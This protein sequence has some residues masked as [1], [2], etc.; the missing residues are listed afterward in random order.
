MPNT[1]TEKKSSFVA[2]IA[3]YT[4]IAESTTK[5]TTTLTPKTES[6]SSS[7]L[8]MITSDRDLVGSNPENSK[9]VSIRKDNENNLLFSDKTVNPNTATNSNELLYVIIIALVI[10]CMIQFLIG[11]FVFYLFFANKWKGV[12][13]S[14]SSSNQFLSKSAIKEIGVGD[15]DEQIDSISSL[16]P[17][18]SILLNPAQSSAASA[19]LSMSGVKLG[20]GPSANAIDTIYL[21]KNHTNSLLSSNNNSA[22]NIKNKSSIKNLTR[23]PIQFLRDT[24]STLTLKWKSLMG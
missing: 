4:S 20:E 15:R 9:N 2:A 5:E 12:D 16:M 14:S 6:A 8:A 18:T 7:T 21:D 19:N 24:Q 23:P 13:A 10:F 17:I 11:V 22:K 1:S 3:E